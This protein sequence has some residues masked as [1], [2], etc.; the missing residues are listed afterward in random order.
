MKWKEE[1]IALTERMA[2]IPILSVLS[3]TL[4]VVLTD[5][6]TLTDNGMSKN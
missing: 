6:L 4:Y 1:Q 5:L 3:W 2:D